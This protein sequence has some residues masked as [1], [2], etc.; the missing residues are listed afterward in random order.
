MRKRAG[1]L[2][3][4][5]G[6]LLASLA[7]LLVLGMAQ[8]S[9]QQAAQQIK[10]VYVV[11]IGRDVPENTI[12]SP[13]MLA[14]KAFPADFAPAGA[15]ATVE[16]AT[17]KY[18]AGRLF[19]DTVLLRSQL[20]SAKRALDLASNLPPGKVAFWLAMPDLIA[21]AGG[22]KPGDRIDLLLTVNLADGDKKFYSTQ[23]TLQNVEVYSVGTVQE[24]IE[25]GALP[26]GTSTAVQAGQTAGRG[27]GG[28]AGRGNPALVVLVDHQDAVILKFVKDAEQGQAGIIDIVLRSADDAQIVRTDGMSPDTLV[29]RFKFRVPAQVPQAPKP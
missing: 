16:E 9:Q 23:T 13:D 26:A 12:L 24:A 6:L 19:K 11:T 22:L 8:Q 17:G 1:L 3:M 18:A 15:V 5:L 10:Q 4:L 27:L 20:S 28:A 21:S 14:V 2:L 7:A 29:D 25:S